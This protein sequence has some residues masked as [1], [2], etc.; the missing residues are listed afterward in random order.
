MPMKSLC[1]LFVSLW[2]L[3]IMRWTFGLRL[4]LRTLMNCPHYATQQREIYYSSCSHCVDTQS[5]LG[6]KKNNPKSSNISRLKDL[7]QDNKEIQLS[8]QSQSTLLRIS[9]TPHSPGLH[10]EVISILI[11][12]FQVES[13]HQQQKPCTCSSWCIV[14]SWWL[15]V[16]FAN[17]WSMQHRHYDHQ[18]DDDIR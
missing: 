12:T 14:A 16:S 15:T 11:L 2:W 1:S 8:H 4:I 18:H 13:V 10:H 5:R 3:L 17:A 7:L 6:L 9:V